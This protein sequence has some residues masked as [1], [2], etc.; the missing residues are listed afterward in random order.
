M[1]YQHKEH[2]LWIRDGRASSHALYQTWNGMIRRCASA[3]G[4]PKKI[5]WHDGI[6]V[7]PPWTVKAQHSSEGWP[8]G[9][10][11]FLDYV[12]EVHGARPCI[13]GVTWTLD[14]WRT[15]KHLRHYL[16][17]C[18]RWSPPVLQALNRRKFRTDKSTNYKWVIGPTSSGKYEAAFRIGGHREHLGTFTTQEEAYSVAVRRRTELG[19][20][21][22]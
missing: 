22:Y 18:I 2:I 20:P 19:L 14:R 6:I 16:P 13:D 5:Y 1:Q 4:D 12:E 15:E 7:H 10:V 17:G 11:A 21:L 8:P 3:E 9:F